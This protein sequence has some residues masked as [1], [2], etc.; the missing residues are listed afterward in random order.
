MYRKY[1]NI[2]LLGQ[3]VLAVAIILV[4]AVYCVCCLFAGNIFCAISFALI[5]YVS[6]YRLLFRASIKELREFNSK[7]IQTK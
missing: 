4:G 1:K 7:Q 6:G 5:G 2:F 3:V